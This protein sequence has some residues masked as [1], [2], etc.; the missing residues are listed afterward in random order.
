MALARDVRARLNL[1]PLDAHAGAYYLGATSPDIRVLTRGDRSETHF[2]D[3]SVIEHQDS[4]AAMFEANPRLSD[5]D[6]VGDETAAFVAGYIGHL[7]LDQMWI[8]QVYRPHFGQLSALGGDARANVMDR[9]L[10]YELDRRRRED[11]ECSADIR[12]ALEQ[13]SVAVN[14][15][16]LDSDT[17]KKW[18][19]V[20][21]DIT[22]HPPTWDR[23]K[24]QGGRHLRGAGIES[25]D[26]MSAFLETIPEVLERTIAHVSTAHIDAY[27][28]RSTEEAF[29]AAARYL[30]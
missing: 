17:L 20:A 1:T 15:G 7:T 27:L 22:R 10:Q 25:E 23:F 14:V 11:P 19:D 30:G 13:S 16:F 21:V 2:F 3:L 29:K 18:R 26:A 6:R 9:V 4:V 5:A 28:E 24:F 8:E 12:A